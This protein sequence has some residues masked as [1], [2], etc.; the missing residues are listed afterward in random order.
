MLIRGD[1]KFLR[2][3]FVVEKH[4]PMCYAFSVGECV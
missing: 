1:F 3:K 2:V 4:S